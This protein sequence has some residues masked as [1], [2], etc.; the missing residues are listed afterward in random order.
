MRVKKKE[1]S[2]GRDTAD[3]YRRKAEDA[4]READ[5]ANTAEAKQFYQEIAKH[6]YLMADSADSGSAEVK[7]DPVQPSHP[8]PKK[9]R[10]RWFSFFSLWGSIPKI[11]K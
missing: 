1:W 10:S 5:T 2:S 7:P 4:D 6:C 11:K 3:Y 9:P 8:L